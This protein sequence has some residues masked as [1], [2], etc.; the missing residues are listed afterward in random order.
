MHDIVHVAS[1]VTWQ[2]SW[3]DVVEPLFAGYKALFDA[4]HAHAGATLRRLVVTSSVSALGMPHPHLDK[5]QAM[6][7]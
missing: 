7:Q 5:D 6:Q 1:A 3:A 2:A 4:A